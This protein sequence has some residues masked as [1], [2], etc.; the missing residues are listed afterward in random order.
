M[1]LELTDNGRVTESSQEMAEEGAEFFEGLYARREL[2][3]DVHTF[4]EGITKLNREQVKLCEG[5]ITEKELNLALAAMNT[6][7][8]PGPDG[9]TAAFF[10][11]FWDELKILILAVMKEAYEKSELPLDFNLS[12]TTLIPKKGK[13]ETKLTTFAQLAF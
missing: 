8:S 9:Y 7:S 13:Q 5:L 12:V 10:R 4:F 3:T 2:S 11:F 1:R 6:S